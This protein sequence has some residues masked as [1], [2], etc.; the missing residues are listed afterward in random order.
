M[1][2]FLS[3]HFSFDEFTVSQTAIRAGIDNTPDVAAHANLVQLAERLE[4]VRTLLGVPVL[5]SSGYR[6]RAVNTLIGGSATSAHVHGLAAD[7]TAPAFG[8]PFEV[9]A[10]IA[11]SG[12][13]FDQII[14]EFGRWVHLGIGRPGQGC[15]RQCL[16]I[17]VGTGY[18][19]GLTATAFTTGG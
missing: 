10:A 7:F 8:S 6:C 19:P 13:E 17:F 3:A 1:P 9:A 12:I 2:V 14:H 4:Q 5:I 18:R 11:E 16:S 15:R